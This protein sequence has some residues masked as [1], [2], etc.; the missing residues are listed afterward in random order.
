MNTVVEPTTGWTNCP[1]CRSAGTF[2]PRSIFGQFWMTRCSKCNY[3]TSESLPKITKKIIYLDQLVLSHMLSAKDDRWAKLL[4][5]LRLLNYLQVITCPYSK[6][7]IDESLLAATSRDALKELYRE[8]S[9][10]NQFL[11]PI[12]IEQD[13]LLDAIRRWHVGEDKSNPWSK[14]QPWA[15]FCN[16]NPHRWAS[17]FAIYAEFP[18]DPARVQR[19]QV[20]KDRLHAY[21]ENVAENWK[22]ETN[23]FKD[24]VKREASS[25]GNTL[26]ETY[27][28][29][30]GELKRIEAKMPPDMKEASQAAFGAERFDP[31]TPPGVQPGVKLVHW[32]A[33]EVHKAGPDERN[34]VSVVEQFFQSKHAMAVPFQ[35]IA[36]RLWATI[37]QRT[38]S[39]KGARISKPSDNYDVT[40]IAHYAPYCDAMMVDNE[41]CAMAS[42][43]NIDVPGKFGVRMF[44][45]KT[46]DEF[47]GYL[48]NLATNIPDDHR[49]ALKQV[50]PHLAGFPLVETDGRTSTKHEPQP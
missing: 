48:D 32:L 13:Q 29:L 36:S 26:L 25:Y 43:N 7:H 34:P 19:L 24:D 33:A 35:Y 41:F 39:P 22:D 47:I 27:R 9:D 38:R 50:Y 15:T 37:G 16:V 20:Q 49:R 12:E 8:L 46:H 23:S 17:D 30:A 1:C 18:L 5:R 42:Q 2:S 28:E 21:L 14:P 44:C 10:G 3:Y 6:V 31:R 40:A 45:S 11:Q 4:H